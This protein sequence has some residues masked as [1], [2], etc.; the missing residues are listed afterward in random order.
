MDSVVVILPDPQGISSANTNSFLLSKKLD[1]NPC[2]LI[3]V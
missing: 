3:N 1:T 2:F